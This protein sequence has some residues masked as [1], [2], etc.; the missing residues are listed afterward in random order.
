MKKILFV[1][2][3]FSGSSLLAQNT[4]PATGNV[5]ITTT[6][7]KTNLDIGELRLGR[8]S[9]FSTEGSIGEGIWGN[10]IVGDATNSQKLRIGVSNDGYTRAEL[11]IDNS[12]R[13]DGTISLKTVYGT[14]GAQTRL[15][16]DGNGNIG[17]GTVAPQNKLEVCGTIRAKEIKVETGWCDYVFED[18]YQLRS[19]EEL[20]SFIKENKHLPE[21]PTA[22]DVE[23]HGV[24]LGNATS[25]LLLKIEEL[26]LYMIQQQKE[27]EVLKM[28]LNQPKN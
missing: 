18:N 28:K 15:F 17:V 8:L 9:T 5:G 27:I 21:I 6:T 3:M 12:N 14:G 10:Y 19:I 4:F 20:E 24:N 13:Q 11:F 16:I 7:P 26:T 25:K 22:A 2:A 1:A 23:A